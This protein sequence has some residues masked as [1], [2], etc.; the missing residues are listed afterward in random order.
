MSGNIAMVGQPTAG[1]GGPT[2]VKLSVIGA[3]SAVFSIGIVKDICLT[4]SL[5]GSTVHFMDI[6]SDRLA[7]IHTFATRYARELGANVRFEQSTDREAALEGADF[8]INTAMLGGRAA[9]DSERAL[10]VAHGYYRG[11]YHATKIAENFRQ[12]QLMR[13]VAHD[14]E[15][16]C[17]RAWLI[18]SSNPVYEG[19]TLI[20][21]ETSIR[22]IG[23][24]HG[25]EG[26][27]EIAA[28]LELDPERIAFE[29]PGVN[30]CI[31]MTK[32]EYDGRDAYP[33]LDAWVEQR[34]ADYWRVWQPR[35][36]DTHMAPAAIDQYRLIGL[37]PLGD[38]ARTFTEWQYH[39]DLPTMQRWY[40]PLGG[41][42]AEIGWSHYL[43]RLSER[44]DQI[45]QLIQDPQ[46][47]LLEAF[48]PTAT[49]EQQVPII[50]A[51]VNNNRGIFQINYPNQGAISGIADDVAIEGPAV[52]DRDG[53]RMVPIGALPRQLMLH[54]LL[55]RV[56]DMER[57]LM[58]FQS[59]DRRFLESI[60]LWDHRTR[61]PEHGMAYLDELME[62]PSN[63]DL[64]AYFSAPRAVRAI[65]RQPVRSLL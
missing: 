11:M 30:H 60:L 23:L 58:A 10:G 28:V 49:I 22:M 27:K 24:C 4:P 59:G 54:T 25:Y 56:I 7:M 51:L 62:Q 5:A 47:R 43:K 20:N 13:D 9:Q 14:M 63:Q 32:F 1:Q 64:K 12:L 42:D 38:T 31:W 29:A 18:Q 19:A 53:I 6:D 52:I 8:V 26:Y 2:A 37:M 40:G 50:D 45:W 65:A 34:S 46:A 36:N 3:G 35:Y 48:P 57:T 61:T 15:R 17:P 39:L 41:F 21:R 33:L 55:P 16:H 44:I